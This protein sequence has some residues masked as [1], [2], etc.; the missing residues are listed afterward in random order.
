MPARIVFPVALI[1]ALA[2]APALASAQS[3]DNI[4]FKVDKE[5]STENKVIV[6]SLGGAAA[7]FVGVGVLFNLDSKEKS[8]EVST[9]GAELTG[10]VWTQEREDTRK[11]ALRSRNYAIAAYSVGG[12]LALATAIYYIATDPG[13]E[14]VMVGS[15]TPVSRGPT[16]TP[17]EGGAVFGA[18]WSWR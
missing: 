13:E 8:D 17:V 12:A 7:V 2:A 9:G 15:G 6:A 16:V 18:R 4:S 11:G 10:E 1:A 5:R 3:A 14:L